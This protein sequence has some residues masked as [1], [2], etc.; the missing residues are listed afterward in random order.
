MF[1]TWSEA[2]LLKRLT[3]DGDQEFGRVRVPLRDQKLVEHRGS[4]APALDET[5]LAELAT[6]DDPICDSPLISV[7]SERERFCIRMPRRCF[8][9]ASALLQ[10]RNGLGGVHLRSSHFV[11]T[12]GP[13]TTTAVRQPVLEADRRPVEG[14]R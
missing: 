11:I 2:A 8:L 4:F 1:E 6:A 9:T 10:H 12:A 7:Q 14:G 5:T 3:H 13:T